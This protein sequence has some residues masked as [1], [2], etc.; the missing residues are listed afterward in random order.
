MTQDIFADPSVAGPDMLFS[1]G[2]VADDA[3]QFADSVP[4]VEGSPDLGWNVTQWNTPTGQIFDPAAPLLADPADADAVLGA[5]V[6][7]WHTGT[8][9]SGSGLVVYGQP[10]N[11][12]FALSA[13]GGAT[14]DTFLQTTGYA[15]GTVTFDHPITFT[16]DER[17]T[18]ASAGTGT[19]IAFNSFT[20]F[21]NEAGSPGYDA[22]MP[23]D[24]IFLQVPLTDFRGEPASYETISKGNYYQTIYN[25]SSQSVT[26]SDAVTSDASVNA[27]A[28]AAD[29]GALHTVSIDLNQALLRLVDQM[30]L[31][32]PANAAAYLDFS[33][34]SVGSV[35]AGVETSSGPDGE[36]APGGALTL[37]I[38]HPVLSEDDGQ[39]ASSAMALSTVQSIDANTYANAESAATVTTLAGTVTT[40]LLTGDGTKTVTSRGT[41]AVTVGNGQT[42]ALHAD[43]ASLA[44]TGQVS[45]FGSASIDGTAALAVSGSF[46]TL[47]IVSAAAGDVVTGSAADIATLMLGGSAA[48]VDL[49]SAANVFLGG[50]GGQVATDGGLVSLSGAGTDQAATVDGSGG[51]SQSVFLNGRSASVTETGTGAQ[52][53]VAAA[54]GQSGHVQLD[55]GLGAQTLWTGGATAQVAGGAAGADASLAVYAQAGSTVAMQLGGERTE[56]DNDDGA[57]TVQGGTDAGGT[58]RLFDG[59]G[60]LVVLGGAGQILAAAGAGADSLLQITAGSGA[61]TIFG[62]AGTVTVIGSHATAGS[63]TI[64]NGADPTQATT[65]FGGLTQQT[66]WTGQADDTIVAS[67]QAGD[68]SGHIQAIVQGGTSAYWGGSESAWLDNQDGILNAFLRG[69]GAVSIL[70]DLAG[71]GRTTLTGY[72]SLRDSLTLGGVSDP[73]AVQLVYGGGNTTL[74]VA[75]STASVTL[76]GVSHVDLS[77][78]AAGVAVTG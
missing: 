27:L 44:V 25:L 54:A 12:T 4:T 42:V 47:G 35:Y 40:L 73:S 5:A 61:Q 19:A 72:N 48:R 68:A 11:Y 77:S 64:V 20:V 22:A 3:E 63:Q 9:T 41:D 70:A 16:A 78:F 10:G 50:D 43:G 71:S 62:G 31:Q 49:S 21:F 2:Q 29:D 14:R 46:G 15:P 6:A 30:A 38:A 55:G 33:R 26:A 39:T 74:S 51:G 32:D 28:F 66:I 13:S 75:G 24:E 37:D 53:V 57:V 58:A 65:I 67:G 69:D 56:I 17:L 36:T 59:A 1:T 60:S 8:A 7:S 76:V 18:A 45:T 52:L 23:T 34:W